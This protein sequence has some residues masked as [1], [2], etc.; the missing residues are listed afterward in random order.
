MP[1]CIVIDTGPLGH[2]THPKANPEFISKFQE[3]LVNGYEI[4]IPEIADY[5]L[6]RE[7]TRA[8]R[9][10]SISRLD[11][12]ELRLR[13]LPCSTEHF[14]HAADLWAYTRNRGRPT[15][16]DKALDGDVLISAQTLAVNGVLLTVDLDDFRY[17]VEAYTW[18]TINSA[19]LD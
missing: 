3:L 14:R 6:R 13:Y 18:D 8:N 10:R 2:I 15:A 4:V 11:E 1:K 17:L 16:S 7:L 19:N 9:T 5:E 12:W